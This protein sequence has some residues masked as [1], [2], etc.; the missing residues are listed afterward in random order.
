VGVF[1]YSLLNS[2]ELEVG[3]LGGAAGGEK[4][5]IPARSQSRLPPAQVSR[6][7]RLV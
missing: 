7:L 6:G 1:R 2:L 3:A 5:V 4:Q